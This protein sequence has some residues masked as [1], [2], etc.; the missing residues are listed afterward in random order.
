MKTI[1]LVVGI[2]LV[3]ASTGVAKGRSDLGPPN[4]ISCHNDGGTVRLHYAA[5]SIGGIPQFTLTMDGE[6]P[7]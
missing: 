6:L 7:P 3:I 5:S 4:L 1:P 2:A